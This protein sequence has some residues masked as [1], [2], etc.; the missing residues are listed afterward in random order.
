M[1]CYGGVIAMGRW[2]PLPDKFIMAACVCVRV[3][4]AG[5]KKSSGDA[6]TR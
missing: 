3:C 1:M 2:P 6:G 4:S 5:A